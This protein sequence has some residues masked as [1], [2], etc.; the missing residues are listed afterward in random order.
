[1]Q[2]L[3]ERNK[4]DSQWKSDAKRYVTLFTPFSQGAI[5]MSHAAMEIRMRATPAK[6]VGKIVNA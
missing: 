6:I 3:E 1:M 4:S 2:A 5:N